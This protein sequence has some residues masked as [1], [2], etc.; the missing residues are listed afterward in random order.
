[1]LQL[2]ISVLLAFGYSY[3]SG[4]IVG[5]NE[6]GKQTAIETVK[7]STDYERLGGDAALNAIVVTDDTEPRQ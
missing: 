3:D 7:N 1:M 4:K 2:L 5:T 6:S